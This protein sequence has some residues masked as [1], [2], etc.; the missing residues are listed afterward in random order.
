MFC[1]LGHPGRNGVST[2][3]KL[4]L[5]SSTDIPCPVNLEMPKKAEPED[6]EVLIQAHADAA[7]HAREGGFD[8]VEIHSGYGGY[9]VA[10]FLSPYANRRDDEWGGSLKNRM[11]LLREIIKRVR[12]AVGEDFVVGLQLAGDEYTPGGLTLDDTR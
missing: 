7:V 2:Y 6:I 3:S 9:L 11:R 10:Q 4:A 8:G 1:Q 5:V 12:G